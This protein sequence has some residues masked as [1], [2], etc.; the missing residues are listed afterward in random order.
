[1]TNTVA[2]SPTGRPR[3][4]DG[5]L[6]LQAALAVFWQKGYAATS[7]DDLTAAMG[8]SRSSFYGAFGSKHDVLLA[9][10]ER[11]VDAIYASLEAAARAEPDTHAAVRAVVATIATPQGGQRGCL[12]VNSIAELAPD[13]EAVCRLARMQ[14]E[15]V[16][17]LLAGL[18]VQA[19]TPAKTANP[20]AGALLACTFGATT[21]RKAGMPN[22]TVAAMVKH[23]SQIVMA[24]A[25][26]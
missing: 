14:V 8:L 19:G 26:G 25:S 11:Y 15:R 4:F 21:L 7:L 20:L 9:S 16:V 10:I 18:L 12:L 5:G 24:T 13:D 2:G 22:N 17:K 1:M 6:A 23:V 3:E